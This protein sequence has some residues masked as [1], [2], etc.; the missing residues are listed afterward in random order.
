MEH[1]YQLNQ[2][3]KSDGSLLLQTALT[4]DVASSGSYRPDNYDRS[5][6]R[7]FLQLNNGANENLDRLRVGSRRILH[8]E[9]CIIQLLTLLK[10]VCLRPNQRAVVIPSCLL[11]QPEDA[12]CRNKLQI[13]RI[14]YCAL[15]RF[16]VNFYLGTIR[17]S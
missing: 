10:L 17:S 7:L 4:S 13:Y 14:I 12:L 6:L 16:Y 11:L 3:R 15:G 1:V 9:R 5:L 2:C 8:R